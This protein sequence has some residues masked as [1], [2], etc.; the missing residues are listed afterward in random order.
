M[1]G[2]KKIVAAVLCA[3]AAI[4]C[5]FG[6]AAC[7]DGQKTGDGEFSYSVY[8]PDGA[9]ALSV[10][11][12]MAEDMQFG[13]KV[14]YNVINANA[15]G[16]NAIA[17]QVSGENAD[18]CILPVNAA[19][20]VAGN[21]QKYSLLGTVT[22]GNL[23]MISAKYTET[24]ITAE[25][26]ETLVGKTVGCI[27]LNNFVGY[28]F[29]MIL[30]D[31]DINYEIV[32]SV[33][34]AKAG[35][36]NIVSIANPASEIS[37]AAEFDYMVAAEPVVTAKING[38]ASSNTPLKQVGDIQA[39]YGEEGFPQAVMV[40]KNSVIEENPDFISDIIEA[41][42]QNAKW[43]VSENVDVAEIVSAINSNYNG[44]TSS[45]S[46]NNLNS[47]VIS[48]C[49]IDFVPASE[50]KQEVLDFIDKYEV[51]SGVTITVADDFF[52]ML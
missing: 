48:R 32:E 49:A 15:T 41:V 38:S 30:E 10:A 9:P 26:L 42:E 40:A 5:A 6:F 25:N 34:D 2:L 4:V 29:R 13:G 24:T 27:Q 19:A 3:A 50:C 43:V 35:V 17:A 44:G 1:K 45:L 52:Y 39:L 36:V 18:V 51:I 46:V 7:T 11:Q 33:D 28:V 12:L 23:Y 8:M 22:H 31:N 47:A 37:P 16:A 21:G 20:Q 14:T